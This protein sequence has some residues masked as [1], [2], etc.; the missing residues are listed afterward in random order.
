[1]SSKVF[2]LELKGV[3]SQFLQALTASLVAAGAS[4][5]TLVFIVEGIDQNTFVGILLQ[6]TVAGIIGVI[7]CAITYHLL[8]SRELGEIYRSL[9]SR[10]FRKNLVAPQQDTL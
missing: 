4:Y 5:A 10:V 7:S 9:H 8:G 3:V 6:G 1:M 2:G